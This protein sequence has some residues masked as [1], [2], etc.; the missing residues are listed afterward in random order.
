[1]NNLFMGYVGMHND[2]TP[3]EPCHF[4]DLTF[5]LYKNHDELKNVTIEV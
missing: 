1:M 2:M 3:Y 5:R 4:V